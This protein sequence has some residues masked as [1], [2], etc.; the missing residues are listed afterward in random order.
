M[1]VSRERRRAK[2][3]RFDTELPKRAFL[4][5]R[6]GERDHCKMVAAIENEDAKRNVTIKNSSR[7]SGSD[8]L[9]GRMARLP[10]RPAL[11]AAR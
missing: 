2:T 1:A 11:A 10:S 8:G 7:K 9:K 5:W 4:G 6:R 3:D